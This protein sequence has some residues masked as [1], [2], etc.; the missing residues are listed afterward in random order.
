MS[1]QTKQLLYNKEVLNEF[2][3]KQLME[4][5]LDG[6]EGENLYSYLSRFNSINVGYVASEESAYNAI[7]NQYRKTGFIITYYLEDKPI[8]K[9][10]VGTK[11]DAGNENW[12]NTEY[13]K[14]V[15]NI[16]INYPDNEDLTSVEAKSPDGDYNINVL[17][18][19]NKQYNMSEFNGLGRKYLRKNIS[20]DKNIL[21]QTDI[22]DENT[23]YIIQ[24][25]FDLNNQKVIIPAN[26]I[27]NF[28]GGSIKNGTLEFSGGI[29]SYGDGNLNYNNVEIQ[30]HSFI[31]I[32][33]SIING[34]I[35]GQLVE[36]N[37]NININNCT[38]G[39]NYNITFNTN[40]TLSNIKISNNKFGSNSYI[41][42]QAGS[43]IISSHDIDIINNIVNSITLKYCS[44]SK[45]IENTINFT[46]NENKIPITVIGGKNIKINNNT[47]ISN[48]TI[49][50]EN[51]TGET[52][53]KIGDTTL[54][55]KNVI[56]ENIDIIGNKVIGFGGLYI[57]NTDKCNIENNTFRGNIKF[58]GIRYST[59]QNNYISVSNHTDTN[60]I[61]DYQIQVTCKEETFEVEDYKDSID[62][63]INN[64]YIYFNGN[65][66]TVIMKINTD[67]GNVNK[68]VITKNRYYSSN[69]NDADKS[70]VCTIEDI[71]VNNKIYFID[72]YIN[73]KYIMNYFY[74]PSGTTN[75]RPNDASL[76]IQMKTGICYFDTD[77]GR[78]I[79]YNGTEWVDSTGKTV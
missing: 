67:K 21:T 37:S 75:N 59:V 58:I 36:G 33:N 62:I 7:P 6:E 51:L 22:N 2:Y 8:T 78:P 49:P 10:F 71:S 38:F 20:E 70:R 9:Q 15:K 39:N 79:W 28:Q 12:S 23:I 11:E 60:A 43:Q 44:T 27:L 47:I 66:E 73:D 19:A 29:K 46:V 26:S 63:F 31:T 72:Y 68:I 3:P 17:K 5:V 74:I 40:T 53:I 41:I 69:S 25:D 1:K 34:N 56:V 32:E 57:Y 54:T 65:N 64:N 50:K 61:D 4:N 52:A 48:G 13:W 16:T 24:Y 45:I 76:K 42:C 55:T 35:K 30:L 18:F 14:I 77:L